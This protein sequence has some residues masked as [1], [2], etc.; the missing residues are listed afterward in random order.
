MYAIYDGD[1]AVTFKRLITTTTNGVST[2]SW[3]PK[4]TWN[5]WH[6]IPSK[7]PQLPP[8]SLKTNYVDIPGAHGHLD[9]SEV[10]TNEPRFENRSGSMEFILMN[11]SI[12]HDGPE[13]EVTWD[14]RYSDIMNWLHGRNA[15]MVLDDDPNWTWVA[16]FTVTGF[17][18]QNN[19]STIQISYDA[20]P[21]KVK[22]GQDG[23]VSEASL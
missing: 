7:R 23:K 16:R 18:S 10:L 22:F 20:Y 4:H 9:L 12:N 6:L 8:P 15:R 5:D 3:V 11:K 14:V 17:E 1:H 19:Y 13:Y 2:T 21:Y